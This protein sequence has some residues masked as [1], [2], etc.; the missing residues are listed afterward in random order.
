MWKINPNY[1]SQGHVCGCCASFSA[2]V[3][4]RLCSGPDAVRHQDHAGVSG[5]GLLPSG[6][7]SHMAEER[8]RGHRGRVLHRVTGKWWLVLPGNSMKPSQFP[9]VCKLQDARD[10]TW[11]IDSTLSSAWELDQ[12]RHLALCS[13]SIFPLFCFSCC[14]AKDVN[15]KNTMLTCWK[16][17]SRRLQ[18]IRISRCSPSSQNWLRTGG[19]FNSSRPQEKQSTGPLTLIGQRAGGMATISADHLRAREADFGGFSLFEYLALNLKTDPAVFIITLHRPP[20]QL[21]RFLS[22]LPEL[23]WLIIMRYDGG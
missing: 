1:D 14:I 11:P 13:L 7:H 5:R 10:E 15:S 9:F 4:Q 12:G 17:I 23:A 20:Q 2:S 22:Q 18:R 6:H 19:S 16:L 8:V 3:S 21:S